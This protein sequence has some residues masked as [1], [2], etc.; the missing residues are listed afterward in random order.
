M[1]SLELV[2]SP[3]KM[4]SLT[5]PYNRLV[6]TTIE[7]KMNKE[8]IWCADGVRTNN[9]TRMPNTFVYAGV[10]IS[11]LNVSIHVKLIKYNTVCHKLRGS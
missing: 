8:K 2:T 11:V 4:P 10:E 9:T 3:L 6:F 1:T 7:D 5:S